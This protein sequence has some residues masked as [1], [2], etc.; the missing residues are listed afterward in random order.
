MFKDVWDYN[1]R[2]YYENTQWL[3]WWDA[4]FC[5]LLQLYIFADKY[6]VDQLRDDILSAVMGHTL[7]CDFWPRLTDATLICTTHE[8]LPLTA[9]FTRF[10]S[11]TMAYTITTNHKYKYACR[12][13]SD[14]LPPS[15]LMEVMLRQSCVVERLQGDLGTVEHVFEDE[16]PNSCVFHEHRTRNK[17]Q[18]RQRLATCGHI[19]I[20]IID[21]CSAEA[22][23]MVAEPAPSTPVQEKE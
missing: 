22:K 13:I 18:C 8:H 19:F 14:E 16:V 2:P 7:A 5:F 12:A 1:R 4:T 15:F 3:A 17:D 10:L 9:H 23:K 11:T 6:S 20:G 21:A